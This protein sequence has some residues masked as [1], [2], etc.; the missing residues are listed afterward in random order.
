MKETKKEIG[1]LPK[2]KREAVELEYHNMK[3]KD[4]EGV[5]ARAKPHSPG[6]SRAL[7]SPPGPLKRAKEIRNV[8][9]CPHC[10]NSAPQRLLQSHH[11]S[12][13]AWFIWDEEDKDEE[14]ELEA[15]YFVATCETCQGLLLYAAFDESTAD[16]QFHLTKLL[17]PASGVSHE[18]IPERVATIYE[19]A[20]RIK[21]LAPNAFAVQIRRALEAVC[22]D[23]GAQKKV[24]QVMLRE[25]SDKGEIPRVLAEMTDVLRLLG[26]IGAHA[27]DQSVR[28]SQVYALDEFFRAVVE[29]VY[30]APSK[31]KVFRQRL[32]RIKSKTVA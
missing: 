18:S 26:N 20:A 28:P 14:H 29:Y 27:A 2:G 13:T 32:A 16:E 8:A 24:L 22:E 4:L 31:L 11:C 1:K 21:N 19:E 30:I 25:L 23:R 7:Q 12:E 17:W 15:V 3:A 6:S 10:G 9:F 5:M